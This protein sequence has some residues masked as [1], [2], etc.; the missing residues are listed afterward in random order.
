MYHTMTV[1]A[2]TESPERLDALR[3]SSR[4]H[5]AI[6][7]QLILFLHNSLKIK[8]R[9]HADGPGAEGSIALAGVFVIH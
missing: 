4:I 5:P 7:P 9:A 1:R 6:Y 8:I 2:R 3:S